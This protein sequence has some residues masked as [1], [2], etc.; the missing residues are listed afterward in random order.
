MVELTDKQKLA[1]YKKSHGSGYS[2]DVLEEVYSRGYHLWNES[3]AGNAEQF[4]F[5]RVNS[6]IA[7]GFAA[8][9]DDDLISEKNTLWGNIRA[10]RERIKRGSGE[11]MRKPGSKGAPTAA[12]L[13]DSQTEEYTGSEK[14]SKNKNKPSSRF[15]ATT[16]LANV[17]KGDTPGQSLVMKTIKKVVA[18]NVSKGHVDPK[19]NNTKP[20]LNTLDYDLA[21]FPFSP[22]SSDSYQRGIDV[23]IRPYAAYTFGFGTKPASSQQELDWEQEN[24]EKQEIKKQKTS[25]PGTVDVDRS[26]KGDRPPSKNETIISKTNDKPKKT[27]AMVKEATYKGKK[28]PLNK[29][30]AGDVKKS[31]VFVDPDG[32]GKAQKVN[33][34]DKN[35]TIK[36][37]IKGNK[38]SYCARSEPLGNDPAKANY[39]SRKAWDC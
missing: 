34:G 32:D 18:E 10:K 36:K 5:D 31:K 15:D 24:R 33:F 39:W 8:E 35:M 1:L 29:P 37:H 16:S 9:L 38:D 11:R 12:A 26:G 27:L 14:V 3:F 6:F 25:L 20:K 21:N 23:A 17:Y 2:T 30:M 7:G 22:F 4:G 13:K 19:A 28:V